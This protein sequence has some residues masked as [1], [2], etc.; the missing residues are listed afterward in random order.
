MIHIMAAT[1]FRTGVTKIG[2]YTAKVMT[3]PTAKAHQLGSCTAYRCTFQIHL[4]AFGHHFRIFFLE[5]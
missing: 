5:A 2:T 1:F 4:Y 3:A